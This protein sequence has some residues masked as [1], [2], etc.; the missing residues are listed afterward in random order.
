MESKTRKEQRTGN[1]D[2]RYKYEK[3]KEEIW[4]S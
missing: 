3:G 4:A 2:N 1:L